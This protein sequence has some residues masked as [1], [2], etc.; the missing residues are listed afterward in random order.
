VPLSARPYLRFRPRRPFW[1]EVRNSARQPRQDLAAGEAAYVRNRVLAEQIRGAP[2]AVRDLL[3]SK[4]RIPVASLDAL[5]RA[6]GRS[7]LFLMPSEAVGDTV[8]YAGAVREIARAFGLARIGI[9]FSGS[10]TDV[11]FYIGIPVEVFP[12]LLPERALARFDLVLDFARDIPEL[13]RV[14]EAPLAIDQTILARLGLPADYRWTETSGERGIRRVALFPISS[15]PLRTIPPPLAAYLITGLKEQELTVEV[16]VD[17]RTRQGSFFLRGAPDIGTVARIVPDLATVDALI[18][19]VRD[20]IDYGIFCDSGPA[21]ITKLFDAPGF[22][23]FTSVGAEAVR[24]PFRNLAAWQAGYAG[25]RC[26]APCGLVGAMS[27]DRGE[28]YGCMDS[29]DRPR[30]ALARP[31][32]L[33]EEATHRLLLEAPVGCVAALVRDREQIL[34]AIRSDL[35]RLAAVRPERGGG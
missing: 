29:L 12:L 22:C 16:V 8:V 30:A 33:P 24:G 5:R 34:A 9:A 26:R 4:A 7:A 31:A 23:L 13:D 19:Y 18:R 1:I 28:A 14:A 20:D 2:A 3:G 15:T 21:H 25:R 10:A 27:L 35:K 11:W 17:P 6:K 32:R